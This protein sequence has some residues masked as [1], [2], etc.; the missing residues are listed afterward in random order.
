MKKDP[1]YAFSFN[2]DT[3]VGT[4]TV[5]RKSFGISAEK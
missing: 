5:S 3:F 2:K 4:L 1:V